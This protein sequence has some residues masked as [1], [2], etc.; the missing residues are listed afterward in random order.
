[1]APNRAM[2]AHD[3]TAGGSGN[4]SV[5]PGVRSTPKRFLD[6][7]AIVTGGASGIG[8]ATARAFANNGG[9]VAI[10]D[11]SVESGRQAAHDLDAT[12]T[13]VIFCRADVSRSDDVQ[14]AVDATATR[15]GHIDVLVN[16]AAT[17]TFDP[18]VK[19]SERDWDHVLAVNVKSVFL[20]CKY[21]IPHMPDGSA[22][23][24][25]SSVHAH[26]TTKNVVPYA[27]S[28]GAIEAFTRGLS[29]ELAPKKIRINCVAP[30]A[31]NTPMLWNNPNV[32]S[33]RERI[34]GAIAEPDDIARTI[35]FL[36]SDA[37]RFINGTTVVADG[38]RL[39]L[40]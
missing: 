5:P 1:M 2:A 8:L 39:D 17:M 20:F 25:V 14:A 15:W 30:G 35:L 34:S 23:V 40:L 3:G 31:V 4:R 28:K 18:L 37:A 10:V 16:N 32:K 33:G 21:A 13:R 29:V 11:I 12:G 36:A 22:I 9:H 24:N 27:A 7:V 6:R 26:E 38:G 19:V